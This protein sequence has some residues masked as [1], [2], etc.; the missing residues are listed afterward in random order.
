MAAT[1]TRIREFRK[2]VR[3]TKEQELQLRRRRNEFPHATYNELAAWARERFN[4]SRRLQSKSL[5][6]SSEMEAAYI[7]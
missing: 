4:L 6:A 3:L 5:R 2:R 1:S 7:L